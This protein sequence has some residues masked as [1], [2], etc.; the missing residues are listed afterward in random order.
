MVVAYNNPEN[1]DLT[2]RFGVVVLLG[3]RAFRLHVDDSGHKVSN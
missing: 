3:L 2:S 1:L